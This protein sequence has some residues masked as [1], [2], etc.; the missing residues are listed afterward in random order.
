MQGYDQGGCYFLNVDFRT[1]FHVKDYIREISLKEFDL[2][3]YT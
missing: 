1:N 2:F 3:Y